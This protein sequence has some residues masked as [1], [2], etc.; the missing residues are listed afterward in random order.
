MKR[1]GVN[2]NIQVTYFNGEHTFLKIF[3]IAH[4]SYSILCKTS[5]ASSVQISG[6]QTVGHDPQRGH[7]KIFVGRQIKKALFDNEKY[8]Y[9]LQ[10]IS[11]TSKIV[12]SD[13][14]ENILISNSKI[15]AFKDKL[16]LRQREWDKNNTEFF[17]C[18]LEFTK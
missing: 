6:A 1:F 11:S 7:E 3:Y 2:K 17:S 13:N 8:N 5:R 12:K 16:I 15:E 9:F 14:T 4:Y 18:F 10:Q